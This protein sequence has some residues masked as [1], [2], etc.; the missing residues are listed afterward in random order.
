M[1]S[2]LGFVY[3]ECLTVWLVADREEDTVI[4]LKSFDLRVVAKMG[5]VLSVMRGSVRRSFE[6]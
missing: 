4:S 3:W 5:H 1:K 6:L 2:F